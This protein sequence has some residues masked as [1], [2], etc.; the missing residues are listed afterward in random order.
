[1]RAVVRRRHMLT[2]SNAH[3][4]LPIRHQPLHQ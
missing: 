3:G 2:A 1:M 4:A